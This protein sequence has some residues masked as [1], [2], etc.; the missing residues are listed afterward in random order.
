MLFFLVRG[1]SGG[2]FSTV[3][4]VDNGG[5]NSRSDNEDGNICFIVVRPIRPR[6]VKSPIS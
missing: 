1:F 2:T 3:A 4:E 5:G 6:N